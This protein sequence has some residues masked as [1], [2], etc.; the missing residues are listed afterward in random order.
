MTRNRGFTLIELLVVM[1]I[2]GL[3]VGIALPSYRSY[4][5][6]SNRSQA[7]QALTQVQ[8]GEEKFFMQNNSYTTDLT[9]AA[10]TGLGIALTS[11]GN[12]LS[13]NY[14]ITVTTA[15]CGGT[16]TATCSYTATATAIGNQTKDTS[17]CQTFTVS[18]SGLRT[19]A[20][21]TGCW[22]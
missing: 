14:A 13:G 11:A 20:D 21:S 15:A 9:D 12:T 19:P 6:K 22:Q 2:V 7:W 17:A 4:V 5:L 18:S 3:L 1:T 16:G 8:S 10:P